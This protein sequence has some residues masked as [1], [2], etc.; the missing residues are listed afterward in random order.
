MLDIKLN[1]V[2]Y[3]I[4]SSLIHLIFILNVLPFLGNGESHLK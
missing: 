2:A 4:Q 1:I 3:F